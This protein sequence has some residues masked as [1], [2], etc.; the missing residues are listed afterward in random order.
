[1]T[2]SDFLLSLERNPS[3][4]ASQA[5]GVVGLSLE[6][7]GVGLRDAVE[8]TCARWGCQCFTHL[9]F[10]FVNSVC[11]VRFAGIFVGHVDTPKVG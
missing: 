2:F 7:I 10:E 3:T 1:M 6:E 4:A 11:E 5:S 8:T 9:V